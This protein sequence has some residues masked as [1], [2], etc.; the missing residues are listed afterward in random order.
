M[1]SNQ[2]KNPPPSDKPENPSA[3]GMSPSE[4]TR[5]TS[6]LKPKPVPPG[7][8]VSPVSGYNTSPVRPTD[9]TP[10]PQSRVVPSAPAP[11]KPS[12]P[13]REPTPAA[14]PDLQSLSPQ[15]RAALALEKLREKMSAVSEEYANGKLNRAQFQAIYQ[16]YQEQRDITEQLLK[17]DPKTGAWQQ[18]IRPGHTTFLREHFEAKVTSFAIYDIVSGQRIILTGTVQLPD[19]QIKSILDKLKDIIQQKGN[20]GSARRKLQDQR[21][22]LFVPGIYTISVV[23]FSLEPAVSQ[24]KMI[25]DIQNDFERANRQVLDQR[26]L[27]PRQMVFPHRALFEN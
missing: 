9:P 15:E 4:P 8:M 18:V 17:R 6:P 5:P 16:R 10:F 23:V 11:N 26:I 21:W 19:A 22:V 13:T 12:L 1:D 24:I 7:S 20:P 14:E 27:D 3:S 25:E 2:P